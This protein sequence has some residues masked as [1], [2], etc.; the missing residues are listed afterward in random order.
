MI[1]KSSPKI[2]KILLVLLVLIVIGIAV[3]SFSIALR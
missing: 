2:F 3:Y 1:K